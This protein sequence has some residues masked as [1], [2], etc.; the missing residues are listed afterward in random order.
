MSE[1]ESFIF[2]I[3]VYNTLSLHGHIKQKYPLKTSVLHFQASNKYYIGGYIFSLALIEH[4]ILR[5][6]SHS[7][8]FL[9]SSKV[10]IDIFNTYHS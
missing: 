7:P 3:N 5:A 4:G 1:E 8:S 9:M 2:W 10:N 6:C